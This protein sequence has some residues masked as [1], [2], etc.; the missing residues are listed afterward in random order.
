MASRVDKIYGDA[1]ISVK[2]DEDDLLEALEE[3]KAVKEILDSN[4]DFVNFLNHPQITKEEKMEAA[5]NVFDGRV[6]DDMTGFLMIIIKKGRF[7]EFDGIFT[8]IISNIKRQL[9]IGALHVTSAMPL[10]QEQKDK[11]LKK[12]IASSEYQKLE[13]T[14]ETD[15]DIIGGLIDGQISVTNTTIEQEEDKPHEFKTRRDQFCD[16]RTDQTIFNKA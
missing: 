5:K 4:T 7:K 6:S 2:T 11:I 15:K 16:Q 10:S 9:G 1:Y 3:A 12:V 14:Y 8:Y 13:V